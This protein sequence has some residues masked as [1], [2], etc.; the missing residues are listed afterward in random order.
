M[1]Q[2]S[3]SFISWV[4]SWCR[5]QH[6]SERI[7]TC[8]RRNICRSSSRSTDTFLPKIPKNEEKRIVL[9]RPRFRISLHHSFGQVY[10]WPEQRS[11]PNFHRQSEPEG[12]PDGKSMRQ[13]RLM[14]RIRL[15]KKFPLSLRIFIQERILR[16]GRVRKIPATMRLC[17]KQLRL[18]PTEN[19]HGCKVQRHK[20]FTIQHLW[21]VLQG[22]KW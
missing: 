9:N 6:I 21:Q 15:I 7:I 20:H 13:T 18:L 10:H 4:A 16:F 14:L 19:D 11:I 8:Y 3:Q 2:A 5:I 12:Y 1:E 22:K 17:L